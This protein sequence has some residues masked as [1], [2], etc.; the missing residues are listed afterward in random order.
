VLENEE[1]ERRREK[2]RLG[3]LVANSPRR[4]PGIWPA[5]G[6]DQGLGWPTKWRRPDGGGEGDG[7]DGDNEDDDGVDGS[8][9]GFSG[10]C[11]RS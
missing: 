9:D 2:R 11:K 3:P 10:G 6:E 4:R 7:V 1:R 8:D 5:L